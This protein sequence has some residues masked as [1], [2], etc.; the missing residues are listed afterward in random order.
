M[1]TII[2][3]DIETTGVDVSKDRIISLSMIKFL[4]PS[5]EIKEKKYLILNPTIPIDPG[6]TAVHGFTDEMVKDKPTF[7]QYSKKIFHYINDCDYLLTHNGKKF[8]RS[9]LHEEFER[10]RFDWIPKPIIDTYVIM[11][12]MIPRTLEGAFRY[13]CGGEIDGAHNAEN[14]VLTTIEVLKGQ[15]DRHELNYQLSEINKKYAEDCNLCIRDFES[16]EMYENVWDVVLD[17]SKYDNENKYLS[18][19]GKILL[20]EDGIAIWG[21]F[22]KNKN[23][24]V[25]D[26]L[27]YCEWILKNDFPSQTNNVLRLILN[28]SK[29]NDP[30]FN[31]DIMYDKG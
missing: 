2:G 23:K 10:C 20:R 5:F 25:L 8:D 7:K 26:D 18:W 22:G 11:S 24:P 17:K 13:Y 4:F 14:D 28:G 27:G 31:D 3:F 6:A 19:D 1:K 30:Y 16:L 9:L 29:V 15:I 12:N 21:N